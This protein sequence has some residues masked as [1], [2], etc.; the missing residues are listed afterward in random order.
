M[1]AAIDGSFTK[2]LSVN[3]VQYHVPKNVLEVLGAIPCAY[4]QQNPQ[5]AEFKNVC[6]P[7]KAEERET[8]MGTVGQA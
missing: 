5:T 6:Q 1:T 7:K 8:D 4:L 2:V 3:R